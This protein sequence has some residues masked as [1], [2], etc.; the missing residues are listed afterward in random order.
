M[1]TADGLPVGSPPQC[2]A[3][4][5]ELSVETAMNAHQSDLPTA[6]EI[7]RKPTIIN[8]SAPITSPC[9][10]D[11]RSAGETIIL[12]VPCFSSF[13]RPAA[14]KEKDRRRMPTV[15]WLVCLVVYVNPSRRV[16]LAPTPSPIPRE[17]K[18]RQRSNLV[19]S[20]GLV[21]DGPIIG[22]PRRVFKLRDRL[23]DG[24]PYEILIRATAEIPRK[25]TGGEE[26]GC[27]LPRTRVKMLPCR[28]G[29]ET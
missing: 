8:R 23:G 14:Q 10:T 1:R 29:D 11:R 21:H 19:A 12:S 15:R 20:L 24:S 2:G 18:P 26:T 7:A 16:R 25:P 3:P 27:R 9:A 17:T 5:N 22:T 6:A 4:G 13:A 28:G